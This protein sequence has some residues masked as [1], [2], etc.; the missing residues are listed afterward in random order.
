MKT[1]VLILLGS[2]ANVRSTRSHNISGT[3]NSSSGT[4]IVGFTTNVEGGRSRPERDS[5]YNISFSSFEI[6]LM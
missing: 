2:S 5:M 3:S 1:F 4:R 6:I